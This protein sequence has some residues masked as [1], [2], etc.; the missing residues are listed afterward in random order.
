MGWLSSLISSV[1]AYKPCYTA[2][3]LERAIPGCRSE[4]VRGAGTPY[5]PPPH[6]VHLDLL[7]YTI[8]QAPPSI[9]D[10]VYQI[11]GKEIKLMSFST[12]EPAHMHPK[13]ASISRQ[14]LG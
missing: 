8:H 1:S 14:D 4:A 11:H 9:T 13:C 12:S 7:T 3:V 2:A 5:H 6:E 10:F